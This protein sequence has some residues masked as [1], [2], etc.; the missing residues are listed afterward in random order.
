MTGIFIEILNMSINASFVTALVILIRLLLKKAPKK[1]SYVLWAIVFFRLAVPFTIE[2]PVS[3]VPVQMRSLSYNDIY[4]KIPSENGGPAAAGEK[5]IDTINNTGIDAESNAAEVPPAV[6]YPPGY[7]HQAND[8]DPVSSIYQS[9]DAGPASSIYPANSIYPADSIYPSND[10][11]PAGGVISIKT[12][13]AIFSI[14]WFSGIMALLLHAIVNYLHLKRKIRTSILVRDNIY[15]TDFI[16]TPFV[17]G[18]IKPKIYIPLGLDSHELS[19]VIQH[20]QVHIKR[21]DHLIKPAAFLI[22]VIH[23]FNPLA[24]VAYIFISRDMELSADEYILDHSSADIGRE[25]SSLL[26]KLSVKTN[27]LL[28]PLAFGKSS[29]KTRVKNVLGYK[30]QSYG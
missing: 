3:A 2:M 11:P 6:E 14:I 4:R 9:N 13:A 21:R 19:Y 1:Y 7:I 26:L 20:E 24:W 16:K 29:I 8:T 30:K 17:F 15:E 18:I 23:W 28:N 22:T 25:Y 10:A 27:E 5:I 12:I